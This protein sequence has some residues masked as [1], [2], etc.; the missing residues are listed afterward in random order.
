MSAPIKV[1]VRLEMSV[2]TWEPLKAEAQL[3][4]KLGYES[5]WF[6]DHFSIPHSTGTENSFEPWTALC[7]VAAVTDRIKLGTLVLCNSWRNPAMLAKSGATVDVISN[8]RLVLGLGAGFTEDEF[9]QY[10]YNFPSNADRVRGVAE[11]VQIIRA[12]WTEHRPTFEGRYHQIHEALCEP[13]PIQKPAPDI[14]VGGAGE[15]LSIPLIA[16]HADGWDVSLPVELY[17]PKAAAMNAA[18]EKIGRDPATLE[19]LLNFHVIPD[20]SLASA[21]KRKAELLETP[22]GRRGIGNRIVAGDRTVIEQK[23]EEF[24]QHGV[25]HFIVFFWERDRGLENLQAFS[26]IMG[27]GK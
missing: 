19:R 17:A 21:E 3:A 22:M 6:R 13:K 24:K 8:G 4:D 7:S 16:K 20:H 10:G 1:G 9:F 26:E 5:A 14:I 23:M 18:C 12:M 11:A 27:I 15:Q 2:G 25:N